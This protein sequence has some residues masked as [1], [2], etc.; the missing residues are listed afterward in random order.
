MYA[1][2]TT[3]TTTGDTVKQIENSLSK[4]SKSI[5][6]WCNNNDM[7]LSE[8]KSIAMVIQTKQRMIRAAVQ[9]AL[10]I[11]IGESVIPTV[12]NSKILGVHFDMHMTWEEHI[13]QVHTKIVKLLYLLRQIKAYLPLDARKLF[14]SAYILPHFDLCSSIWGNCSATLFNDLFKLQK[15]AARIILDKDCTVRSK[16]LFAKLGWMPLADRITYHRAIQM[17][18]CLNNEC[19]Q[20]LQGIFK[21]NTDVHSHKTRAA[22]HQNLYVPKCH[23]KSFLCMGVKTW[24]SIPNHIR[25]CESLGAFKRMYKLHYFG[26]Q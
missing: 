3:V 21:M 17:Y 8:S 24:N 5:S 6:K 12:S 23:H 15:K 7:V 2:D 20:S 9:E 10:A 4:E 25:N 11:E 26:T 14:Y 1:D 13:N 16:D 18:K 22:T 19:P